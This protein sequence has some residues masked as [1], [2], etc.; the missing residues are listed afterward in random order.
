MRASLVWSNAVEVNL[1]P[2]IVI[3]IEMLFES[4]HDCADP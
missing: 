2:L 3:V 1:D 4:M